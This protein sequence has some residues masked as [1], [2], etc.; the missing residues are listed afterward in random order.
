MIPAC[1]LDGRLERFGMT[2]TSVRA[3]LQMN[4]CLDA[5]SVLPPLSVPTLVIHRSGDQ[6]VAVDLGREAAQ[7][8]PAARYVE[9]PGSDHVP[10]FDKPEETLAHRRVRDGPAA[11]ARTRP[12]TGHRHV[13]R[14]RR[15]DGPHQPLGRP[16]LEGP[17][18]RLRHHGRPPPRR[19]PRQTRQDDGRRQRGHLRRSQ[20]AR[21]N[22]RL[23]SALAPSNSASRSALGFTPARS[24]CDPTTSPA[25]RS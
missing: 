3:W 21:S 14:H 6:V 7:L 5:R 1:A 25:S 17:A 13:H 8:I 2:P 10:Y 23:P 19:V 20:P 22:A 12:R 24:N 18:R 11:R 9:L 15:L 4:A 16:P